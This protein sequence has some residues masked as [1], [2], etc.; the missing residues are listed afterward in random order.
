[1]TRSESCRPET[2]D[3]IDFA[4]TD[5]REAILLYDE[6]FYVELAVVDEWL[7]RRASKE[8][9]SEAVRGMLVHRIRKAKS[10]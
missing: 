4:Q 1:M 5:G 3:L 10:S 9:R 6:T 2:V 8:N 7:A